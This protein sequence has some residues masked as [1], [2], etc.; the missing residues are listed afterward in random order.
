[1]TS[2][3]WVGKISTQT[4]YDR[5]N[6]YQV[7]VVHAVR[8]DNLSPSVGYSL[9]LVDQNDTALDA[10]AFAPGSFVRVTGEAGREQVTDAKGQFLSSTKGRSQTIEMDPILRAK[11]IVN[12]AD[13]TEISPRPAVAM[14]PIATTRPAMESQ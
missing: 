6:E 14:K 12:I 13:G 9:I 1:M 3:T 2:G 5:D 4:L 11:S 8:G 10:T 7:P